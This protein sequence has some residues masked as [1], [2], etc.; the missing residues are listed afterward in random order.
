M[1]WEE[2]EFTNHLIKL[3]ENDSFYIFSDGFV[4]Q[5]GGK[6]RKKFKTRNFKKL[7]LAVQSES[8]EDQKAIIEEAFENWRENNEQIDDVCLMGVRI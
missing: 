1:H 3:Q 6:K 2:N 8:M 5:Y 4:D 7:L